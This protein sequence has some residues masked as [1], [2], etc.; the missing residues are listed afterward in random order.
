[1]RILKSR[2]PLVEGPCLL[3]RGRA[4]PISLTLPL[5]RHITRPP[6]FARYDTS[7][8]AS[9]APT[10]RIGNTFPSMP[11]GNQAREKLPISTRTTE[12]SSDFCK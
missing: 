9:P 2:L 11:K 7:G 8:F 1:M 6:L 4:H 5:A 12:M 10:F 3:S